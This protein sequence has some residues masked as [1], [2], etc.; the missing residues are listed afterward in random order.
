MSSIAIDARIQTITAQITHV[1][2]TDAIGSN[3]IVTAAFGTF[4]AGSLK[5]RGAL[6]PRYDKSNSF[7]FNKFATSTP[8]LWGGGVQLYHNNALT[9]ACVGCGVSGHITISGHVSWSLFKGITAASVD[10]TGNLHSVIQ[11]GVD[12]TGSTATIPLPSLNIITVPLSPFSI[13]GIINIGPQISAK[14]TGSVA[15]HAA[16]RLFAGATLNWPAIKAT[17][18][19]KGSG[20]TASGFTPTVDKV[21]TVSGTVSAAVNVGVPI[22]I[23]I[24]IS[25]L[26]GKINKQLA[27]VDT[28]GVMV[29]GTASTVGTCKGVALTADLSN[30]VNVDVVGLATIKLASFST[31]LFKKCL[32]RP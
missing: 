29:T 27:L 26:N 19:F 6:Y 32:S 30:N 21:A 18:N 9:V 22:S 13:P 4:V 23:G 20:A 2:F 15:I 12:A 3:S 11:I 17:L 14:A 1:S 28:P 24:G 25:V 5:K 16:G 10:T 8:T 7:D 31:N